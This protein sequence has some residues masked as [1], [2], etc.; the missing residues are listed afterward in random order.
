MED[1]AAVRLLFL[2]PPNLGMAFTLVPLAHAASA[3]GHDVVFATAS[4]T[5]DL[6]ARAGLPVVDVA[7]GIDFAAMLP[8]AELAFRSNRPDAGPV[9]ATGPHFFRQYADAMTPGALRLARWWRPD[10]VVH[11]PE[12]VT[13]HE[14]GV[15][16]VFHGLGVA[17]RPDLVE[18]WK[19][20]GSARGPV[21]GQVAAIDVA[22][23]SLSL[24]EPYGQRMRYVPF[25]GGAVLPDWL[26]SSPGRPRIVVTLGTVA[27]GITGVDPLRQLLNA[28]GHVPAE[29]VFA[30][31]GTDPATLG[32]LPGNVRAER[33]IPLNAV[34]REASAVVHHGG[35]G[36][37]LAAL[38]AGLPQLVLPQG[39]DQFDNAEAL[40][41]CGAGVQ[42]EEPG[43]AEL[44]RL[45]DDGALRAAAQAVQAEMHA[46][47]TPAEVVARTR[48]WQC[49]F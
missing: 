11:V 35:A 36:S 25:H 34:L 8:D 37:M 28:A 19:R 13:A 33:W 12:G 48:E 6:V 20:R 32:P 43:T 27:P 2:S 47:P 29:F 44:E 41:K 17:H 9:T 14:L 3:A 5:V 24:V 45:L 30:L 16:T 49:R 46:L 7:P 21:P 4:S 40:V 10:L 26:G 39:A 38:D 31:G 22:P 1:R 15:P 42:A 18:P 23:P